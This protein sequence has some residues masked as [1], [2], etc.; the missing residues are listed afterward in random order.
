MLPY[1]YPKDKMMRRFFAFFSANSFARVYPEIKKEEPAQPPTLDS[2]EKQIN[3]LCESSKVHIEEY[4]KS[5]ETALSFAI[6]QGSLKDTDTI[7]VETRKHL[8]EIK[9]MK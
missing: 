8:E 2:L 7:V 3:D 1:K 6:K 9:E 5:S 4:V